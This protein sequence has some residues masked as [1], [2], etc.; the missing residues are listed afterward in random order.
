MQTLEPFIRF[1]GEHHVMTLATCRDNIPYSTPLFF[2]YDSS[3]NRFIFATDPKTEH[4]VQM[5]LN[6][7]GAIGI[8]LETDSV[9][10]V[11]GLQA[12]GRVEAADTDDRACYFRRFPYA[13]VMR[14]ELWVFCPAWMKLTDNRLG[15]GKKLIW[16]AEAPSLE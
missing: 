2:A 13:R 4:G 10:N 12:T 14:P 6:P 3:R 11:Q 8:H 9:G 5:R 15:F 1:I 7:Q 16:D